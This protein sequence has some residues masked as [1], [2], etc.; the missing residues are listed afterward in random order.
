[1]WEDTVTSQVKTICLFEV[2]AMRL[3]FLSLLVCQTSLA[4]PDTSC[5]GLS[6]LALEM[7]TMKS[8]MEKM[9][10]KI[11]RLETDKE[12]ME[13]KITALETDKEKMKTKINTLETDKT[14]KER[15]KR[16]L[17]A[18][19]P[20]AFQCAYK[21][22]WT[23]ANSY[24]TWDKL[25]TN[26]MSGVTGGFSLSTGDF[27][28]GQSGVW[29]VTFAMRSMNESGEG[30]SANL[31]INGS[32]LDESYYA[33]YTNSYGFVE[34]SG[35]RTLFIKLNKWDRVT[36]GTRSFTGDYLKDITLCFHLAQPL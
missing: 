32:K 5:P 11:T 30:M 31:Y 19:K 2:S 9:E 13:S 1:M 18:D 7:N 26:S 33:T 10:T 23:T 17:E 28:V 27:R 20:Y 15:K 4:M 12:M 16:S 29:E 24:I 14:S 3:I 25:V 8:K 22:S 34:S 35:S 36:L 6:S 21:Y